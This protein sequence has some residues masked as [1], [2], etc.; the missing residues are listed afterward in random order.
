M[1]NN[2]EELV[3]L[4]HENISHAMGQIRALRFAIGVLI[5][6]HSDP[7]KLHAYWQQMLSEWLEL[8]EG[9]QTQ[10][11]SFAREGMQQMLGEISRQVHAGRT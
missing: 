3:R 6:S 2:Q 11:N 10:T 7:E 8:T 4:A 9:Q 5:R 1:D